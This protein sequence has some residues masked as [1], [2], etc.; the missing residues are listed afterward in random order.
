MAQTKVCRRVRIS[1][2]SR[3][4]PRIGSPRCASTIRRQ[5]STRRSSRSPTSTAFRAGVRS[6]RRSMPRASTAE[7]IAAA[8]EGR[9]DDL[10]TTARRASAEDHD[11]RQQ[12]EPTAAAYRGRA[13]GIAIASTCC[14]R[15]GFDIATR[16]AL[17]NAT[18]LHWAAQHGSLDIVRRL[19][20]AGADVDGEGDAHRDRRAGLGD[21][22]QG[23]AHGGGR[24]PARRAAPSRRSSPRSRS[25]VPTS[26]GELV[27]DDPTLSA[28]AAR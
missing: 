26:C 16:D 18:A 11:H 13:R 3:S 10:D 4:S 27:A 24:L 15:H 7:I 20:D 19:I 17:D 1:N 12:L 23:G 22:L 14:M 25:A 21:L 6:K 8:K 9:A 5:S 2:I 28:R